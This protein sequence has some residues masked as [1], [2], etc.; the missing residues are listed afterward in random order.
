MECCRKAFYK[1]KCNRYVTLRNSSVAI[2]SIE[3]SSQRI[4]NLYLK[5]DI[6]SLHRSRKNRISTA[7]CVYIQYCK[8]DNKMHL[9]CLQFIARYLSRCPFE[10]MKML[11][12]CQN[13]AIHSYL[14]NV[15]CEQRPFYVYNHVFQS[16]VT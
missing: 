12:C 15:G 2:M 5:V 11:L 4:H 1:N 7:N 6:G 9:K 3:T 13:F 14:T 16:Q 8:L 10:N